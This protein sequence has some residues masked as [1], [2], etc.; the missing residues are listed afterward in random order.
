MSD[1]SDSILAA[2]KSTTKE[3]K[4]AKR[5]ADREDRV[6]NR[7][8]SRMRTRIYDMSIRDA[9]FYV[10][11]EAYNK[12]SS[13]GKFY[14]NARQI[15]YAARP[16]ILELTG[17][18]EINDV[19]FTQ[20]LLKDYIEDCG[21]YGWKVVWDA[22]G[23]LIEPH[24][25][26]KIGLGGIDVLKY[27]KNWGT[28]WDMPDMPIKIDT[29]GPSF[30]FKN[31]LFIEKE[32]FTE[33]LSHARIPE[34]YDMAVMS[35]KGIPVKAACDLITEFE[36]QDVQVY[37]LRDFDLEGFKIA[38]TLRE[39]TRMTTG[40]N[41]I[42]LGLRYEDIKDLESE[43]VIYKQRSNPRKYLI[44]EC[45]ATNQEAEILVSHREYSGY[46]GQRVEL[47]AMTS[48]ELITW[49]EDKFKQ[50]G[51]EKVIPGIDKLTEGYKRA[52]HLQEIQEMID[53]FE[54]SDVDIPDDLEKQVKKLIDEKPDLS[55]DQA[56]WDIAENE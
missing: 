18:G 38:R 6:S 9:A 10:M 2:V 45:S 7:S 3:F 39:G 23:H 25:N 52:K 12:A 50:H 42:D 29:K 55:W 56:L 26:Y 40:S 22:R 53:E 47:N 54:N 37:L 30:R 46:S 48:E 44:Y 33:I 5:K 34:R 41:V 51:I 28:D 14:A 31:V 35:T 1:I 24:T 20:T 49:L 27:C 43:L 8:L 21:K 16:R 32:G 15:M 4:S 11:E 19:Y 36:K 17:K 13:N